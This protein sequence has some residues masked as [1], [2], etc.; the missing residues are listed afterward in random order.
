MPDV[1]Q[2]RHG[3]INGHLVIPLRALEHDGIDARQL[4]EREILESILI[5]DGDLVS[6]PAAADPL[7]NKPEKHDNLAIVE[8][9][10]SVLNCTSVDVRRGIQRRNDPDDFSLLLMLLDAQANGI[11]VAV[12]A[13]GDDGVV[14]PDA[15]RRIVIQHGQRVAADI[16]EVDDVRFA[17]NVEIRDG[18]RRLVIDIDH[19]TAEQAERLG[20]NAEEGVQR[21]AKREHA[22]EAVVVHDPGDLIEVNAVVALWI[23]TSLD[24]AHLEGRILR[25]V[26]H[27]REI[28]ADG[29]ADAAA[30]INADRID[31]ENLG[32][33]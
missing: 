12:A 24:D 26:T 13:D 33:A 29:A 14:I 17:R 11:A 32:H 1:Q 5:G 8:R 20:P 22:G 7:A 3:W 6:L 25:I 21:S 10:I 19:A 4:A 28:K 15:V 16:R 31:A 23:I 30:S 18:E 9:A 27:V 2:L